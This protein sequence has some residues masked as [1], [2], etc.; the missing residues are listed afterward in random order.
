MN[1]KMIK[2]INVLMTLVIVGFF[3]PVLALNTPWY[4]NVSPQDSASLIQENKNNPDFVIL[5]VRT[6]AE[7]SQGRIKGSIQLDYRSD[8]FST[9]LQKLDKK[10]TYLIYCRSG[11]RSGRTLELMRNLNF[12]RVYNMRGGIQTWYSQGLPV[13]R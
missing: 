10:K 4:K 3:T 13:I 8:T 11:N 7:F 9:E 12:Q 6:P 2:S 5:D 1:R